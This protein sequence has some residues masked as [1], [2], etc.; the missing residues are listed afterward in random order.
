MTLTRDA[1]LGCARVMEIGMEV[2]LR[3]GF[4][5]LLCADPI[6]TPLAYFATLKATLRYP[7]TMGL[8]I[9]ASH[10]PASYVG[11][12]FTVPPVRAIGLDCGPL[13]GLT[14]VREI[15][16]SDQR[17]VPVK[18]GELQVIDHPPTSTSDFLW[19]RRVSRR[20]S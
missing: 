11:V 1:R 6:S 8:A 12:K 18:G 5:V 20:E 7:N 14:R 19:R 10:N 17:G 4:R 9:T 2:A 15:Y 3:L 16:H 13:G